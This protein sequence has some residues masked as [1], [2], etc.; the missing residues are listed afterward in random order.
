MEKLTKEKA[1]TLLRTTTT[2]PH[3]LQHALAVSAAMGAMA[4]HF[5]EDAEYW[6]AV[7]FLHD[8]DYQQ[9]PEEHLRHTEH[10]LRE[11]GVDEEAIRAILSHGWNFCSDVKPQSNMEPRLYVLDALTGLVSATAKMRPS[12]IS[13]LEPSSVT[14]KIKDKSFAAG[15]SRETIRDGIEMLGMDRAAVI[16][17]CIEGMRAHAESLGLTGKNG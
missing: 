13:D 15:V 12:G 4:K 1:Q 14:K 3:L 5:G 11:A 6:E 7:G 8:Y 16:A 9:Y 2:Q 10:P 17:V